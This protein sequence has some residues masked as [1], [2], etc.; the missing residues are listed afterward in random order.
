MM[1]AEQI[2][3]RI[4]NLAADNHVPAQLILQNYM[5][6]RLLERIAHSK[7]QE[8]FILKGGLLI[9]AMTGIA[10]RT[11]MDMDATVHALP[12]SQVR[13]LKYFKKSF[14]LTFMTQV[15]FH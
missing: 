15:P 8:N 11:T 1:T 5:L 12:L 4:R 10:A 2:K 6:E 3:G 7:Y 14:L 13:L 9:S